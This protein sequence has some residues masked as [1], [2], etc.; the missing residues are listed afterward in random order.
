MIV[1]FWTDTSGGWRSR[2]IAAGASGPANH[3]TIKVGDYSLHADPVRQG[4]YKTNMLYKAYEGTYHHLASYRFPD[5]NKRYPVATISYPSLKVLRW[6]YLGGPKPLVCTGMVCNAMT[7]NGQATPIY[8]DPNDLMRHIND[9]NWPEW[10]G[11]Y[12]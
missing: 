8:V 6:K 4:W 1:S 12:G 10:K 2:W 9:R 3:C 11:P 7:Y 5:K